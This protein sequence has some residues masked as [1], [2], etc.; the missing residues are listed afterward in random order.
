MKNNDFLTDLVSSQGWRLL[1]SSDSHVLVERDNCP[2]GHDQRFATLGWDVNSD[3]LFWGHYDMTLAEA[4][5]S[6]KERK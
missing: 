3:H 2:T 5:K 1:D 6:L 4:V